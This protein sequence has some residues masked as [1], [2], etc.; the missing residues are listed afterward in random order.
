MYTSSAT[1]CTNS[2]RTGGGACKKVYRRG[3]ALRFND[4][5]VADSVEYGTD[6]WANITV[7]GDSQ[8]NSNRHLLATVPTSMRDITCIQNATNRVN[9][10]PETVELSLRTSASSHVM[11]K[12]HFLEVYVRFKL[13]WNSKYTLSEY[14]MSFCSRAS[15]QVR[16][17]REINVQMFCHVPYLT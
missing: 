9:E 3:L 14:C 11:V 5:G 7:S 12:F 10:S 1:A 2:K 17:R 8:L 13:P 15:V 4:E 16:L 6:C